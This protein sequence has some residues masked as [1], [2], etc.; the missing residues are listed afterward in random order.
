M[1]YE[2]LH[3]IILWLAQTG[4]VIQ[5]FTT[6][7]ALNGGNQYTSSFYGLLIMNVITHAGHI[8]VFLGNAF[9]QG[10]YLLTSISHNWSH[11]SAFLL[12]II[13]TLWVTISP[14]TGNNVYWWIL[15]YNWFHSILQLYS[16]FKASNRDN[17]VTVSGLAGNS[18][19]LSILS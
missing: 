3:E 19:I 2:F 11:Y 18:V 5:V 15:F 10:K 1:C 13:A 8:S 16:F 9:A 12:S 17:N 7:I 14:S 4:N 6:A